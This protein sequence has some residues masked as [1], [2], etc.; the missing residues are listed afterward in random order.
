MIMRRLRTDLDLDRIAGA[1]APQS[2]TGEAGFGR[3]E[4][5]IDRWMQMKMIMWHVYLPYYAAISI[6][7][8]IR[9][10]HTNHGEIDFARMMPPISVVTTVKSRRRAPHQAHHIHDKSALTNHI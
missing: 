6:S 7:R 2:A 4:T 5:V 9:P 1:M 3:W 8:R 10:D